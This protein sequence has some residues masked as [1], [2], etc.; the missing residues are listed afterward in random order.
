MKSVRNYILCTILG[1]IL[2]NAC[3]DE[4]PYIPNKILKQEEMQ[5]VLTDILQAEAYVMERRIPQDSARKVVQK[6]YAEIFARHKTT[7]EQFYESFKFYS[8][9]PKLLDESFQPIIDSLSSI[10]AST[11]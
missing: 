10:E 4:K 2:L 1:I 6:L 11:R 7:Q 3:G 5:Y 9:H 8:G